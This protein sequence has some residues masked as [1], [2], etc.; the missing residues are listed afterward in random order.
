MR[1]TNSIRKCTILTAVPSGTDFEEAAMAIA[2]E[3][4]SPYIRPIVDGLYTIDGAHLDELSAA[5]WSERFWQQS[6]LLTNKCL[7]NG[8]QRTYSGSRPTIV[9][10]S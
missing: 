5:A 4:G 8:G 2:E 1:D 10:A 7:S 3:L 6:E 9:T